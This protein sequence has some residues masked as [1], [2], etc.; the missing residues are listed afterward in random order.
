MRDIGD[1]LVAG[2]A[3]VGGVNGKIISLRLKAVVAL[4]T[5][6]ISYVFAKGLVRR[7]NYREEKN[8]TC[9]KVKTGPVLFMH[10]FYY[11]E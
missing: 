2:Y 5:I 4:Q 7:K 8:E 10:L 11:E 1:I 9:A 6:T 3:L